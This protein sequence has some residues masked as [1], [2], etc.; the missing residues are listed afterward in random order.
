MHAHLAKN[1]N[2]AVAHYYLANSLLKLGQSEKAMEEYRKAYE[3]SKDAT[4]R[5]YCVQAIQKASVAQKPDSVPTALSKEDAN[6][7]KSLER[8]KRQTEL[9]RDNKIRTVMRMRKT[10]SIEVRT[11]LTS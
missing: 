10:S 4:L 8:I 6:V 2:D 7:S 9:A 5:Q 1:Q 11:M 3:L